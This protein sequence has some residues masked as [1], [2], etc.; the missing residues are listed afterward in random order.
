MKFCFLFKTCNFFSKTFTLFWI[1]L[2][3]WSQKNWIWWYN[4]HFLI[5]TAWKASNKH[6]FLF[7]KAVCFFSIFLQVLSNHAMFMI[8]KLK[9]S[10]H[11]FFEQT[12]SLYLSD[13]F[14]IIQNFFYLMQ[15]SQ[16]NDIWTFSAKMNW[17]R[18]KWSRWCF[19]M[20]KKNF[21]K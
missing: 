18:K 21:L 8:R 13:L 5:L 15:W 12:Y 16:E 20:M 11:D 4:Q 10:E 7:K 17:V 6:C 14:K 2:S 1:N 9:N 3:S 19:D